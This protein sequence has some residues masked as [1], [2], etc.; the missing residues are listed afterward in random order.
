MS[1]DSANTIAK[2]IL[3]ITHATKG[4]LPQ[5]VVKSIN[6]ALAKSIWED[7]YK[8]YGYKNVPKKEDRE[9]IYNQIKQAESQ[10]KDPKRVKER[11]RN[12]LLSD[13]LYAFFAKEGYPHEDLK[14]KKSEVGTVPKPTRVP[15]GTI[16]QKL[17]G[18]GP[19][20]KLVKRAKKQESQVNTV[21]IP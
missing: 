12:Y 6:T 14:K 3:K 10:Y 21:L 4:V 16:S 19:G 15:T 9:D 18:P 2:V 7:M 17:L 11:T 1:N 13:K 5:K 20:V 8:R